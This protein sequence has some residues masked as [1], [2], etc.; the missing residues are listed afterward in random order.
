MLFGDLLGR[1][2]LNLL[3]SEMGRFGRGECVL[4]IRLD[5]KVA[6]V[7]GASRGIGLAIARQLLDSGASVCL[8]ARKRDGLELALESLSAGNRVIYVSG[9]I[10]DPAHRK[11]A[12]SR[13]IETFGSID[14]FVNNAATNAQFGPLTDGAADGV[15]KTVEV[16]VL[17]PLAWVQDVWS[18]WMGDHGGVV[19]NISSVAGIRPTKYIGGYNVSKAALIHLTRQ[20]ALELAPTVRVNALVVGL[21]P[22]HFSQALLEH[23]E[24]MIIRAHPLQRLGTPEDIAAA[25]V[26]LL[27]EESS[28]ITGEALTIDGGGS[29]LGTVFHAIEEGLPFGQKEPG[30]TE[31]TAEARL[32]RGNPEMTDAVD[33]S[34]RS[35]VR[36]GG[37]S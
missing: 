12:V 4:N 20:M 27:S 36:G 24:E 11:I 17:A 25:A 37:Y 16:N 3:A 13:T 31:A 29:S 7:T 18:A 26:F 23:N 5:G 28:W 19:L 8:T 6:L 21:V 32:T 9:S 15:R 10:E 22:T 1:M 2:L 35:I 34:S 30:E 33:S 14:L